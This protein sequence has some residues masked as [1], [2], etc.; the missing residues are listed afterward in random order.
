M[1]LLPQ[2]AVLYLWKRVEMPPQLR[3]GA[4]LAGPLGWPESMKM[5]RI[6]R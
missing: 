3:R 5:Y 6:F 4:A 1:A 2:E